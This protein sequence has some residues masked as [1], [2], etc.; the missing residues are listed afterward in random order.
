MLHSWGE[1]FDIISR[2][3]P[4]GCFFSRLTEPAVIHRETREGEEESLG[5]F[6][7]RLPIHQQ[8]TTLP[9]RLSTH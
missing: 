7:L 2:Y 8:S 6:H 1:K 3:E 4:T 9:D 5:C